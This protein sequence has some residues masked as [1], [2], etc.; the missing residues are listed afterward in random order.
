ME[1]AHILGL[2]TDLFFVPKIDAAAAALGYGSQWLTEYRTAAEFSQLLRTHTPILIILD[3][4]CFL[5]WI[6]WLP[7]SKEDAATSLIPWLVFGS[8]MNPRRLAAA[9]KAGAD[10]VVPKSQ[11][12]SELM[13][14]MKKV[15][16]T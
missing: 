9:R 15:L 4:N 2:A 14:L 13:D 8:H 1:T 5:P 12:S 6:E 3:V 7:A 10:L 16:L 11:F